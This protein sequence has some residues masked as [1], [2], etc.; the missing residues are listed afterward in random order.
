MDSCRG[1]IRCVVLLCVLSVG[2]SFSY[3]QSSYLD[4]ITV[5]EDSTELSEM[6]C[7][8]V[9]R[10]IP[11][12]IFPSIDKALNPQIESGLNS[13][14]SE[15]GIQIRHYGTGQLSSLSFRGMS[16]AHTQ[17]SFNGLRIN[18]PDV[19]QVNASILPL[20]GREDLSFE[21]SHVTA[22]GMLHIASPQ[23]SQ[24]ALRIRQVMGTYRHI[25][26]DIGWDK[27][28]DNGYLSITGGS[29]D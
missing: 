2:L 28:Y 14:A 20:S 4:S 11:L 27:V 9:I 24:S 26:H 19:S 22:G 12:S 17:V 18:S 7:S 21:A 10:P 6:L 15:K 25:A 23:L 5:S 1:Y 29:V 3:G 8:V 13:F 16:A